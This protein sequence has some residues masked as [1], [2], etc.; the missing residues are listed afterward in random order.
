MTVNFPT[1]GDFKPKTD[2]KDQLPLNTQERADLK[3]NTESALSELHDKLKG[4]YEKQVIT[5]KVKTFDK[6]YEIG[7]ASCRERV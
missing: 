2:Y 1:S 7:R 5:G 3:K 6:G 4:N